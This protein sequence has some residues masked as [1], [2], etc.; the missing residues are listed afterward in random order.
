[1]ADHESLQVIDVS[2]PQ[3][4]F[5]VG[6]VSTP[7]PAAWDVYVSGSYAYVADGL[8]GLQVI[9]I[10]DPYNPTIVGTANTPDYAQ[11][12][13]VSGSYAYVAD[14]SLGGLQ[15]IDIQDPYNPAIVGSAG[16][17]GFAW[18]VFLSGNYLYMTNLS[19]LRIFDVS[20][21]LS[22][23]WVGSLDTPGT[24]WNVYIDGSHAYIADA[25]GGLRVIDVSDPQN[26]TPIGSEEEALY[27]R[28]VYI[29]GSYAYIAGDINGLLVVHIEDT[30]NPILVS[31]S[32]YLGDNAY[33]VYVSGPYAYVAAQSSG[34]HIFDVSSFTSNINVTSPNGGEGLSAGTSYEITWSSEGDIENVKIEYSINNG[35]GWTE[36][37]AS[38][39]NDGSYDWEVPCEN[40]E[41]CL[42]RISDL[43]GDAS[44]VSDAVFAIICELPPN[45]EAIIDFFDESVANG[46]LEGLGKNPKI[47]NFRLWLMGEMLESAKCF[48]EKDKIKA[49]CAVESRS[50]K[51]CDGEP[52]PKDFVQGES[53][54]KLADMIMELMCEQ[55]F[56]GCI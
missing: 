27:A 35:V 7:G 10:Q 39:E 21:P 47:A 17:D 42:I 43:V 38:T 34:L 24:A 48:I 19:G 41:N 15:V 23:I 30:Y 52:R 2:D 31:S 37:V 3:K 13:Y 51:R 16:I 14:E 46:T 54:P 40:S 53:A 45:I 50:Y 32:D 22:P 6:S 44:D 9:D 4:P 25:A 12:V 29:S 8:S 28:E 49:A 55:E 18:G 11:G 5:V 26:P 1:V 20:N 33:G 36:V 56:K